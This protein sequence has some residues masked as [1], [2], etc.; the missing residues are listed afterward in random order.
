MTKNA[1][2]IFFFLAVLGII[3]TWK[4]QSAFADD[5]PGYMNRVL[6][7]LS[8][9]EP[10]PATEPEAPRITDELHGKVGKANATPLLPE[11]ENTENVHEP[12]TELDIASEDRAD[13][14]Q[15]LNRIS[16]SS[17]SGEIETKTII[18]TA[19]QPLQETTALPFPVARD[20]KLNVGDL[21][22]I[23]V[24]GV[25]ELSEN[26]RIDPAGKITIPLVGEIAAQ[27][28]AK[29]EVQNEIAQKLIQGGYYN[30]PSV[31][32]EVLELAPFYILGEVK[33]P[34]R[35]PFEPALDIFKAIAIAGGYTPRAAKDKIVI[36]R[37][38]NGKKVKIEASEETEIL[39]GDSIKVKQRFF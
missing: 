35:Y 39:P 3:S 19:Q 8:G 22:R 4:M 16:P 27:G 10:P 28:R 23:T 11:L 6:M 38:V 31:T 36:I 34:G 12:I 30:D 29:E 1:I 7:A 33:N 17:G 26:Y 37:N 9:E 32:V 21:L 25:E 20:Y 2:R 14:P 13:A 24:Y 18:S 5:S 15:S